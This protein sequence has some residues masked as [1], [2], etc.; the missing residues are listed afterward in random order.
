MRHTNV[1][2]LGGSG[3]I[4]RYVANFLVARGCR[5]VVPTRRRA[6]ARH[7]IL[8]PTCDVVE[9]NIMD[10]AT[11]DRLAAGQDAV[12]NLV[13]ILHGR[14]QEFQR[15]HADLPRRVVAACAK[16]RIGRMLQMSALGAS[17]SAPSMYLR[18][19]A[20][21]ESHV[22]ASALAWTLFRPSVVFGVEDR[23][24][25]LF[26]RLAAW[27]PVLPI[28][29]ANARFQPVWVE[30]VARAI[31][32][33]LDN[34]TTFGKTYELA[35]PRVYALRELVVFAAKA[36]GHPRAVIALPAGLA[37]LQARLLE[38]LPG[39]PLLSRD[40][41]DSMKVDSVA[42]QQPFV[43]AAELGIRVTPMEPEAAL[44]LA[45]MHPRTRFS[46]MRARA[47]R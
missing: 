47:R 5:V 26:A 9:A 41:L 18:S 38:L 8:L 4:G 33:A 36:A 27:F 11:L 35:G 14:Q 34:P 7:L 44:Y 13:G 28:G 1:L 25:N 20:A 17:E 23:F 42:S 46:P 43:P 45:G 37:R 16:H 19:K 30:D 39:A 6:R 24:L 40:N 3:F 2:L 10:D 29:G 21:G 31:V 32:N 12:I 15:V 22:R